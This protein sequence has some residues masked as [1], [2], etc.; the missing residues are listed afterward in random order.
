MTT[1]R[2]SDDV[3]VSRDA[4][5]TIAATL[6]IDAAALAVATGGDFADALKAGGWTY[7]RADADQGATAA[8]LLPPGVTGYPVGARWGGAL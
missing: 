8:G 1:L 5:L 4:L 2:F 6:G 3:P 7:E